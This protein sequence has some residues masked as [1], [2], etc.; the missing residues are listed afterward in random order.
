[1]NMRR[2][3]L[4]HATRGHGFVVL[5]VYPPRHRR[6]PRVVLQFTAGL[7]IAFT[8]IS[9]SVGAWLTFDHVLGWVR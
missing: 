9:I 8:A 4:D 3:A 5:S 6:W 1:M 7:V 2:A